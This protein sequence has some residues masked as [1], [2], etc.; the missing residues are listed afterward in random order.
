MQKAKA[1][2]TL[3]ELL[4]VVLIIGILAAV[5]LPQYQKAVDKARFVELNTTAHTLAKMIE[6][7]YL[8]HDKY[9]NHWSA[10]DI[11]LPNCSETSYEIYDLT[12]KNFFVDLNETNFALYDGSR[13]DKNSILILYSFAQ[14]ANNT[15]P[16]KFT[17]SGSGKN[18][19]RGKQICTTIC[20]QH[21]CSYL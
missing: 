21:G 15:S 3:I 13:N 16:G 5:A 10:L 11:T 14:I 19:N 6:S 9:P 8:T 12:C 18:A 1:G 4:V 17:C 7:Y 20:G 2:F